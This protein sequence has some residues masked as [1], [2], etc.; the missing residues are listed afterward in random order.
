MNS[1]PKV[2]AF[3]KTKKNPLTKE[4]ERVRQIILETS[5]T[6]EEDINWS[7]PTFIYKGNIASFFMNSKKHVRLMFRYGAGIP[8]KY[9]LPGEDDKV[10][11]AAKFAD[12][13]DV[14]KKKKALQSI[15][16]EW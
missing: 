2:D 4:I 5:D 15:I 10:A 6:V 11:R 9:K 1:N 7:L 16:K 13:K 14:E 3:L 12:L 8:D